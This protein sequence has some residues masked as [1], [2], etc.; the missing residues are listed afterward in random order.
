MGRGLI[1][2]YSKCG[3][4]MSDYR[5]IF[6]EIPKP[7]LVLWNTMIS[8]YSQNEEFSEAAIDCFKQMQH[9]GH[10]P[11]DCSFVCVI[12]A[13]SNLSSPSQGKQIHSLAIKF[14]IP[15]NRISV[16]NALAQCTQNVVI[17]LMQ[18]GCLIG[19]QNKMPST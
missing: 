15:S 13:C 6:E 19:C 11:D 3:G 8:G 2:L 7:D 1:D 18:E 4:G 10:C 12:S 14:E 16:N 5:K 17:I 9:V